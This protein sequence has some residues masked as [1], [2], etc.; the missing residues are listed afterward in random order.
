MGMVH[1]GVQNQCSRSCCLMSAVNGA[2]KTT[3]SECS[4]REFNAFLLQLEWV[5]FFL[6]RIP[7]NFSESGR[8]NCL[9]DASPGLTEHNH[10]SD[11]RLPGQ[12][13]TADQQCS[14]FWGREYKVEIPSGRTMDDICR[15]LWCGNGGSTIST[16]HP[17]LEG[18]WCGHNKVRFDRLKIANHEFPVVQRGPLPGLGPL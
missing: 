1:D 7:F 9:R 4:V 2:G 8:G 3:W 15:I 11:G 18:S 6:I 13:Y 14:Y 10:L 17:A 5:L 12:R 16:A